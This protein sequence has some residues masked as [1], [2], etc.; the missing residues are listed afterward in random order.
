[1]VNTKTVE[2]LA[3]LGAGLWGCLGLMLVYRPGWQREGS[4]ILVSGAIMGAFIGAI[5]HVNSR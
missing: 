3:I 1:M 4:T 2:G 5:R